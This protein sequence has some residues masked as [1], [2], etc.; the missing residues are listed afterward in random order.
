MRTAV[1]ADLQQV[2]QRVDKPHN[3]RAC[4]PMATKGKMT[5]GTARQPGALWINDDLHGTGM[6]DRG[7]GT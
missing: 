1:I 7:H 3:Q 4:L 2:G 6:S 5:L